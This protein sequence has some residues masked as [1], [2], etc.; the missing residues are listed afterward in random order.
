MWNLKY[1]TDDPIYKTE[2]DHRHGEQP[3]GCQG[4]FGKE[5]DAHGIWSWRMQAVNVWNGLVMGSY[6]TAQGSVCDWVTLL[7][8]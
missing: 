1:G 7:Y 4:G 3:G 8:N 2:I 5:W 6:C